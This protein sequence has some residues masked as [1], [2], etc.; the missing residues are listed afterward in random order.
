M[1]PEKRP[2]LADIVL[3]DEAINWLV[4]LNSGQATE[5]DYSAFAAWRALSEQH[6]LAA[7]E[8][9][10][11]WQGV[12]TAGDKA[13]QLERKDAR[14]KLTRRSV[15][16]GG[17]LA[18]TGFAL[19]KTGVIGPRLFADYTTA[20]GE[21]RSVSLPDGSRVLMNASSALS[22]DFND[23]QRGLELIEGQ[24]TF[25]A[26]RDVVRPFIVKAA[27]GEAR[28]IGTVFDID[29]RR[30][31]VA[32]TVL[33]G[34]VAISTDAN[35]SASVMAKADQRVCYA[36]HGLPAAAEGID[37][38]VETAWRRGKLIFN[39]RPLADVAADIERYR[40]DR[41]VIIGEQLRS[42]DVTGVFDL[43]NPEAILRTIEET[44][45]VRI[46]RMPLVT[47]LY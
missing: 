25:T 23:H 9:E 34:V 11:I 21:Q 18:I 20:I 41:I 38:D 1:D 15:L 43:S 7:Q 22:V 3:S 24:A 19:V 2:R 32:V 40:R 45:P 39:R 4:K 29:V 12:G 10:A 31:D 6:E 17:A 8:A 5:A 27:N 37:A 47:V 35:P 28:A 16:G 26:A 30:A 46:V 33:E 13:R 36:A 42:L 14:A 44:L